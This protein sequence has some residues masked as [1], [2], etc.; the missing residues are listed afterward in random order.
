[1]QATPE[2]RET[3]RRSVIDG[4]ERLRARFPLEARLST[5]PLAARAAYA[6][7]LAHWLAGKA[8]LSSLID[9]PALETLHGLDAIVPGPEG[10]GCYPFSARPTGIHVTLPGGTVA[11]MCAVDALAIARLAAARV[12]ITAC[13]ATCAAPLHCQVEN[14]GSLGH[15]QVDLAHVVWRE[16]AHGQGSCSE[17]LCRNLLFVCSTCEAP[18]GSTRFT[19][20]QATA[21]GNAF[22]AF[23]RTLLT[24]QA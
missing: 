4:L 8:P 19:L 17:Q 7:I 20:P 22:F 16:T 24:Q 23:Q 2:Q 1:M 9:A 6:R 13:C 3:A 11:A 15:D 12:T 21:I 10:L 18:A 5:A 14:D